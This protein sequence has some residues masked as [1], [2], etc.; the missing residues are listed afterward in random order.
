MAKI[1]CKVKPVRELM[2]D[3]SDSGVL[4][5]YL[6]EFARKHCDMNAFRTHPT[7]GGFANSTLFPA[8]LKRIRNKVAP[9]GWIRSDNIPEGVTINATGFLHTVTIEA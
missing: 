4:I 7:H 9:W 2:P 3:N 6:P 1:T 8:I 5:Y